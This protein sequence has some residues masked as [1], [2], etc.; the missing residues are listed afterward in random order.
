MNKFYMLPLAVILIAALT[1]CWE[2][3]KTEIPAS[4]ESAAVDADYTPVPTVA[5]TP[6]PCPITDE[7]IVMLAKT[8]YEEAQVAYWRGTQFGV[9][10]Q[11]RQAAVA[12]TALNRY[13]S[14]G[15]GDTLA[16]VLSRPAQFAYDPAAEPT[17][18]LL[19][20]AQDVVDRWWLEKQGGADVG[21]TLPSDYLFFEGDERENY[22][23]K[24]YE[25]TGEIWDWSLPDP[26]QGG[27]DSE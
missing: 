6:A 23:H 27:D 17:E 8:M 9:S 2:T 14:G 4:V 15:Y 18:E 26:Y 24:E 1:S 10:Y 12:W 13:D 25:K 20:L 5:S 16:E 21:R 3:P 19:W 11:A 22:F 7:E